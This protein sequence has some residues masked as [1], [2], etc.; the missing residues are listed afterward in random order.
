MSENYCCKYVYTIFP[1]LE[2]VGGGRDT[3]HF[4]LT[5]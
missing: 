5:H 2:G 4:D 3:D 1:S